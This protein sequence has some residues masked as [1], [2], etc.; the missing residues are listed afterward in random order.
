[1]TLSHARQPWVITAF[2]GILS[3]LVL[4][5]ATSW[6]ADKR[7]TGA[8]GMVA[9]TLE[10]LSALESIKSNMAQAESAQRGYFLQAQPSFL[11]EREQALDG[12]RSGILSIQR[13]TS[14]NPG[15]GA[16]LIAL[17]ELFL[18]Q[19][20]LFI[21]TQSM[22]APAQL[23]AQDAYFA[24]G[25]LVWKQLEEQT[26]RIRA[27]ETAL[28]ASRI[29]N[30]TSSSQLARRSFGLFMLLL[31]IALC[32]LLI[33]T[34]RDIGRKRR[35]GEALQ[36]AESE[37]ILRQRAREVAEAADRSKA[38]FIANMSHEIRSPLN[39]ILG[40]GY[41]LEQARLEPEARN[42]VR[43]MMA[44]GRTLLGSINDIL[45]LSK[46]E[47]GDMVIEQAP[48]RMT[49]VI[50]KIA[51]SRNVAAD[52]KPIE[53]PVRR[54]PEKATTV[55]GDSL[56]ALDGVRLLVVDDSEI[57]RDVAQRILASHGALVT[58]A[59]NGQAALD[60][61]LAH[62]DKVD[63]VLMDVQMPVMDG[64]EATRQL[65]RLPQFDDLPIVA[66][67]AGAFKT[68]H[69]E[70]QAAGMNHF[71]SKPFDVPAT[72]ALVQRL[73]RRR[74]N[75]A[76][77]ILPAGLALSVSTTMDVARGLQLWSD[78]RTYRDYLQRFAGK[79]ADVIAQ[80]EAVDHRSAATLAHK[81]SGDA[82]NLG[83]PDLH[84]LAGLTERVLS[85]QQD[86]AAVLDQLRTAMALALQE[87]A[88]FAPTMVQESAA[89]E[90]LTGELTQ[91]ART[92]LHA[93]LVALLVALDS[94]NP[95]PVEPLLVTLATLLPRAAL[96]PIRECVHGFDFRGA[97]ACVR[98]LALQHELELKDH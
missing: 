35:A 28:L 84:R 30:E 67:T 63:L 59:V 87:I 51:P 29:G 57:N 20:A 19:S 27:T 88:V 26:D 25:A 16:R 91:A 22:Q 98:L 72:I 53:L 94:D 8:T 23:S 34:Y 96:I 85:E 73:H 79:Y 21:V 93:C 71:V 31:F 58:L 11:R 1:M 97:E 61:L 6:Y 77:A 41:L 36:E 78:V 33:Q 69:D 5:S 10:V 43:Q 38:E 15:Q 48:F 65:R 17:R 74:A 62:P 60:W 52:D 32:L 44:S 49:D 9:H 75:D 4:L 56:L 3:G 45:E 12:V 42:M 86:A 50:D 81:L 46:I 55:I 64:I 2:V 40:L 68:Q 39:A 76:P 54:Q 14:D 90:V 70:A 47:S 83:L 92:D 18:A 7:L 80:L 66:L 24:D 82:A 89:P 13:L 37:L 95:A